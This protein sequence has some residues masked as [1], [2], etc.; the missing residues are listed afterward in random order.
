MNTEITLLSD[1]ALDI[2]SGGYVNNGVGQTQ[3]A[4]GTGA[5]PATGDASSGNSSIGPWAVSSGL[6]AMGA[7]IIIA[8]A[9]AA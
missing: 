7:A 1:D 3:F 8:S 5:Q 9:A 6:F 2:V 4:H